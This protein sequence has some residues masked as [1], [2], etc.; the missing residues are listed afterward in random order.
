MDHYSA[1]FA[2]S[3]AFARLGKFFSQ[4]FLDSTGQLSL[5]RIALA[6]TA[7][8]AILHIFVKCVPR[9]FGILTKVQADTVGLLTATVKFVT[10]LLLL[11]VPQNTGVPLRPIPQ[12]SA[13][14]PI[15]TPSI[16]LG[17]DFEWNFSIGALLFW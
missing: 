15:L 5:A 9:V 11:T 1:G 8:R 17:T 16:G 6:S 3:G 4:P 2:P 13:S 12:R 14:P 10:C 7:P